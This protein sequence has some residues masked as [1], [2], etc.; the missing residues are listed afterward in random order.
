MKVCSV[1]V[2]F[3]EPKG[4]TITGRVDAVQTINKLDFILGLQLYQGVWNASSKVRW[5]WNMDALFALQ[6]FMPSLKYHSMT[7]IKDYSYI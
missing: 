4:V 7:S 5:L 3:W 1:R 2:K 6:C